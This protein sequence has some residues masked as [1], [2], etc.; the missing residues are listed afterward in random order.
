[1]SQPSA[2][3][4]AVLVEQRDRIL[5]IT[6]NRPQAKN[7][8]NA[9]VSRGLADAMDRLDDDPGLSVGRADRGRR[10]VLRGHGP[11]G[12]RPRRERRRR[13]PRHGLHRAAAGQAADRGG[14][15]L[16]AGRRHRACAGH[17]SD[18]C[19]VRTPRS[20]SPRSSAGWWPA[21]AGLLR[22]PQRIPSAIAMELALTG[23]NLPA[24]R[25]HELGLVNVLTEPGKALG[26][27]DRA[28]REDHRQRAARRRRH[29]ADHRRVARLAA[30]GDVARAGQDPD[31]GVRV[32]RRQGGCGRVRREAP[33]AVDRN[34]SQPAGISADL[35][36]QTCESGPPGIDRAR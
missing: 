27:R 14:R 11:Q 6:I 29:Q 24:E 20:G 33:A 2:E 25:A 16:R 9:A 32:E 5:L 28:G 3:A 19:R 7:A 21:A 26:R 1:M 10:L 30:R 12:V 8:V 4:P 17:R 23:E 34:L 22:L 31:A 15:G 13:G 36:W 35:T 18:R